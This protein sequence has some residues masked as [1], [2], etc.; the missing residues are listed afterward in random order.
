MSARGGTQALEQGLS[1]EPARR[2]FAA[3]VRTRVLCR[4]CESTPNRLCIPGAT[5]LGRGVLFSA[6][7]CVSFREAF[8]HAS[9]LMFIS[10]TALQFPFL[11]H[12]RLSFS[13]GD[14]DPF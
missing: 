8:L 3:R 10:E 4:P 9:A 2:A 14:L 6:W 11:S 7:S 5:P 13:L 12:T 1:T